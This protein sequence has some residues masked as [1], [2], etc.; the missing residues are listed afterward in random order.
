MIYQK[1]NCGKTDQRPVYSGMSIAV[2]TRSE[3]NNNRKFGSNTS[4]WYSSH[5]LAASKLGTFW[6]SC[7]MQISLYLIG[8]P[9]PVHELVQCISSC[10]ITL[11]AKISHWILQLKTSILESVLTSLF[12][13]FSCGQSTFASWEILSYHFSLLFIIV[14][15]KIHISLYIPLSV[16]FLSSWSLQ[17]PCA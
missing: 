4:V 1:N 9:V 7:W 13:R 17:S 2:A 6:K 11:A 3:K 10:C 8:V 16:I 15:M 14:L 12:C 5:I